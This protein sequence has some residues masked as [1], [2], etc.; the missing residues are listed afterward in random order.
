VAYLLGHAMEQQA[1]FLYHQHRLEEA[2]SEALCAIGVF[3]KLG[4]TKDME[5]C[6]RLLE[7]TNHYF[8]GIRL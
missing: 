2:G 4:A 8:Q 3:E 6:R 7:W 1:G 5:D